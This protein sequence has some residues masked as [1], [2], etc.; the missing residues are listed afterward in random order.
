MVGAGLPGAVIVTAWSGFEAPTVTGH[1]LAMT[2]PFDLHCP[3]G[4][5]YWGATLAGRVR[6]T[7]GRAEIDWV[8]AATIEPATIAPRIRSG[9]RFIESFLASGC[10]GPRRGCLEHTREGLQ[11]E[12]KVKRRMAVLRDPAFHRG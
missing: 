9:N 4:R 5:T 6:T 1:G 3:S 7:T 11:A 8:P 2:P 10:W 12:N